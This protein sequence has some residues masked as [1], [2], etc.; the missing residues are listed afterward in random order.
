MAEAMQEI[1]LAGPIDVDLEFLPQKDGIKLS[2]RLQGAVKVLCSRCLQEFVLDLDEVIDF[3]LLAPLPPDAPEE[4]D[5]KSEDLDTEFFDGVTIDVDHIVTEQ[6][7]LALPQRPLCHPACKG[8]CPGCGVDLNLESCRCERRESGS[9]FDVLRS[10]KT[11]N[12]SL[13]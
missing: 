9:P 1:T 7:F 5:L 11:E 8:L 13:K 3:M 2:G 12:S 6:I 10:M 4:I